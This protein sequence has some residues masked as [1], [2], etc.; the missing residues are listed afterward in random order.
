MLLGTDNPE[1]LHELQRLENKRSTSTHEVTPMVERP[2]FRTPLHNQLGLAEG[3]AVHLETRLTPISEPSQKVEWFKDGRP[4][5]NSSR[6]KMVS[7]FGFVALDIS[8]LHVGDTGLYTVVAT[9]AAGEAVQTCQIQVLGDGNVLSQPINPQSLGQ[10]QRL[11]DNK[12]PYLIPD[13]DVASQAPRFLNPF[14]NLDI[15]EDSPAHFECRLE[16]V[17]D[18]K[19]RVEWRKDGVPLQASHRYKTTYDF[20]YVALHIVGAQPEDNGRYS[21]VAYNALGRVEQAADLVV[22]G[23][24]QY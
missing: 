19:L 24:N 15:P 5:L 2:Q 6:I 10:I 8:N 11:E 23:S 1:R 4:L 20:G 12:G 17:N 13:Q 3:S 14:K 21:V 22:R 7:D 9:N 16:P 18:P